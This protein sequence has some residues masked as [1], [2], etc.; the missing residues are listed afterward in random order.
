MTLSLRRLS[1]LARKGDQMAIA[2]KDL[3]TLHPAE[4]ARS[5]GDFDELYRT[6]SRRVRALVRRR[7]TDRELAAEVVQDTF[8]RAYAN[9]HTLDPSRSAWPWLATVASNLCVDALRRSARSQVLPIADDSGNTR[10][11][12]ASTLVDFSADPAEAFDRS[13]R[14]DAVL[15]ALASVPSRQRQVL[16]LKDGEG[17]TAEQIASLDGASVEGVKSL[18]RRARVT[19]R[20]SYECIAEERGL[21]AAFGFVLAPLARLRTRA[22]QAVASRFP[23]LSG[24]LLAMPFDVSQVFGAAM[25]SGVLFAAGIPAMASEMPPMEPVVSSTLVGGA[26]PAAAGNSAG[27]GEAARTSVVVGTPEVAPAA[28]IAGATLVQDGDAR[29]LEGIVATKVGMAEGTFVTRT[30]FDCDHSEARTKACDTA[31]GLPSLAP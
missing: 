30:E 7:I 23:M 16:V 4:R 2:V 28:T 20:E 1:S 25:L 26:A 18:V 10:A 19:F 13:Q 27:G 8:M 5:E 3:R 17:W 11:E 9:M 21:R 29:T 14:A 24:S 22:A 12:L 15:S 6:Y 31:E